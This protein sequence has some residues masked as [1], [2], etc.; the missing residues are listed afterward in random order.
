VKGATHVLVKKNRVASKIVNSQMSIEDSLMKGVL[1]GK[2]EFPPFYIPI[3][4]DIPWN[5]LL[6]YCAQHVLSWIP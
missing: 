6:S 1:I 4:V 5:K 2:V 3:I